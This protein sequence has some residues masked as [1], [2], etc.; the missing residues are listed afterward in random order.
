MKCFK[1]TDQNASVLTTNPGSFNTLLKNYLI[2]LGWTILEELDTILYIKNS[3]QQILK[4]DNQSNSVKLQGFR[5]AIDINDEQK[6]F[7]TKTQNSDFVIL[8]ITADTTWT[9]FANQFL[10]YFISNS[11]FYGFGSFIFSHYQDVTPCFLLGK[12][13]FNSVQKIFTNLGNFEISDYSVAATSIAQI[14][15]STPISFSF[16]QRIDLIKDHSDNILPLSPI[17]IHETNSNRVYGFLPAVFILSC[18]VNLDQDIFNTV[19]TH[20]N[21]QFSLLEV[22]QRILAFEVS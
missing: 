16:D 15:W 1:H 3:F 13:T 18:K 2:P 22:N 19:Y 20:A 21:T 5:N 4:C 17:T 8:S 14:P 9:L 12:K 10:F 6:G 11:E 7:P